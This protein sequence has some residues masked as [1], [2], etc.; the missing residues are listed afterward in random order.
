MPSESASPVR[1]AE[2]ATLDRAAPVSAARAG[3]A[4]VCFLLQEHLHPQALRLVGELE[5][6]STV[7][8]LVEFLVRLAANI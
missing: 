6:D 5:P 3:A 2:H 7:R 4:R 1:T 8:P